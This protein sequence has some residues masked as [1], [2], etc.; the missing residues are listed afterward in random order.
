[1]AGRERHGGRSSIDR[2]V[3]W[4][5]LGYEEYLSNRGSLDL[6]SHVSYSKE[7]RGSDLWLRGGKEK[8]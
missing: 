3:R 2:E 1:M 4:E 7:A 6:P 8:R 5:A